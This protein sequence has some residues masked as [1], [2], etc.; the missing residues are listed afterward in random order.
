M[1][2]PSVAI[3]CSSVAALLHRLARELNAALGLVGLTDKAFPLGLTLADPPVAITMLLDPLGAVHATS[4]ILPV[5]SIRI[6]PKGD[7]CGARD[8]GLWRALDRRLDRS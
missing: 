8:R 6:P 2:P 7:V 5:K 4:G 3:A 1:A